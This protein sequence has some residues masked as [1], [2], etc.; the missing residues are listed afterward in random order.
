MKNSPKRDQWDLN[1]AGKWGQ[2]VYIFVGVHNV[3]T[4]CIN[5]IH[6]CLVPLDV[7]VQSA[8]AFKTLY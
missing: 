1:L 4:A 2:L 8:R 7:R 5:W 6:I 3:A